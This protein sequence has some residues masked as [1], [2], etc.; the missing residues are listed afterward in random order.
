[1]VQA[2]AS[3]VK[4]FN[5]RKMAMTAML[6]ALAAGL[7]FLDFSIPLMPGFIK[8]DFSELP[9]LIAAFSLGPVSG[10]VVCLIKNLVNLLTTNTGGVGELSNFILGSVFVLTAGIIYKKFNTRKGAFLGSLLGVVLMAAAGVISN[11][12]FVYPIY[13]K[14]M[15]PMD[16]ILKSYQA[17]YPGVQNLWQ[18]LLI[19]NLPF[20]F[21][22]GMCSV[23]ITLLIYKKISPLIKGKP[24][25]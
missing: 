23:L 13:A 20:T 24:L 10:V 16:A 21:F 12:F 5:V 14:L 15:M 25:A 4:G 2:K 3:K 19:F 6:S 9:A 1:M 17:I 11:Y 7:M 22:K 8:L 18:V